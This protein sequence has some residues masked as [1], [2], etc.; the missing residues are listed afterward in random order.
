M[1][2]LSV[3]WRL[4]APAAVC[5]VAGAMSA[6]WAND[7]RNEPLP[8]ADI[9]FTTGG[10][11][12]RLMWGGPVPVEPRP[13]EV[14]VY[15]PSP[16]VVDHQ[17]PA[18]TGYAPVEDPYQPAS[19][20][21]TRPYPEAI[22]PTLPDAG[23]TGMSNDDDAPMPSAT[24]APEPHAGHEEAI[25]SNPIESAA[26][27]PME[28]GSERPARQLYRPVDASDP[29]PIVPVDGQPH[30]ADLPPAADPEEAMW[31]DTP[32]DGAELPPLADPVDIEAEPSTPDAARFGA[33]GEVGPDPWDGLKVVTPGAVPPPRR[34]T[35]PR[36]TYAALEPAGLSRRR[37]AEDGDTPIGRGALEDDTPSGY[38][39]MPQSETMCR[40]ALQKL[41]VRFVDATS[42]RSSRRCGIDYPVKVSGISPGVA[43]RPAATLNC[44]TALRVAQWMKEEVTPAARWKL[45]R[46]PTALINASSYRCSR[47]A[48]SGSIS[49]HATGSALDVHGFAFAGGKTV[50]IEKKGFFEFSEKAFQKKVRESAC[51][52]FGTV[53]GPGYNEDHADHLHLDTRK[54][55]RSVCK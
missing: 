35:R 19:S 41:G 1:G 28:D 7:W 9:P 42:V 32:P 31:V 38:Q 6:A 10:V 43:M 14:P 21:P 40:R 49:E 26:P 30:G 13:G 39:A 24:E 47:I 11:A 52:Y 16:S 8:P 2:M 12:P 15:V 36:T 17:R 18:P 29:E 55:R 25:A 22:E 5:V 37:S 20:P 54:R 46:K 44:M 34:E 3:G 53:L 23:G 27:A 45:L 4:I 51:R 48:G 50:E 33:A